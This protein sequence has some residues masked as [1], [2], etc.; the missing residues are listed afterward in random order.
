VR[1]GYVSVEAARRDYACVVDDAG[2][3]DLSA[4]EARRREIAS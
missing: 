2:A 4:T 1:L 3:V